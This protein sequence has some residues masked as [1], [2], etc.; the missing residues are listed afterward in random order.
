MLR[1]VI[2][3][4]DISNVE[5]INSLYAQVFSRSLNMYLRF[6]HTDTTQVAE[7]FLL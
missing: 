7:I 4:H 6:L 1:R 3:D 5:F 2:L